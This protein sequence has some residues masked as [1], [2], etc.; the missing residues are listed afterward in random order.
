CLGYVEE[1]RWDAM[2]KSEQDAMIEE[3][4][5]YDDELR[6]RG[7]RLDGG[8]A[9]QSV[10]T[11]KTLRYRDGKVIVADGPFA[12]TKEQLGGLGV[13]EARDMD[14]AID[15][16]SKHPGVRLVGCFEI[17]P[18]DEESLKRQMALDAECSNEAAVA[19]NTQATAMKFACLGYVAE[20]GWDVISREGKDAIIEECIAFD[21]ARRKSG[22]WLGGIG[23]QGVQ[24]AKNLRSN[25]SKV[26]VT[27]GPFAETKEYLGG[28]VVIGTTDMDGAIEL[29]SKHPGLRFGITI[30]I[31]PIDEE[32][33]ARWEGRRKMAGRRDN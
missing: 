10:R 28:L 23:L 8:Q 17:R 21:K 18:V 30:E 33:Y 12:E 13:V 25:G 1:K 7:H 14:H 16:M 3:C 27:D 2:S 29:L 6:R 15:L 9:L 19:A 32:T 4:F 24:T 31:R 22:H 20:K 5:S 11:A 26:I